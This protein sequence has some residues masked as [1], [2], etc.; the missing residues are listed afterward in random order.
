[1]HIG[2]APSPA[3]IRGPRT[4]RSS[5][6]ALGSG[7]GMP[8]RRVIAAEC[9]AC[10]ERCARAD[11]FARHMFTVLWLGY[12]LLAKMDGEP[13][14]SERAPTLQDGDENVGATELRPSRTT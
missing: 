2:C 12:I 8:R 13:I 14:E 7:V 5:V 1:M 9:D 6:P 4:A 11:G 10:L 3:F